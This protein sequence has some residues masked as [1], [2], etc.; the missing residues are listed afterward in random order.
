MNEFIKV[1]DIVSTCLNLKEFSVY[2]FGSRVKGTHRPD[3]DLD[4]LIDD[5]ITI[6]PSIVSKLEEAFEESGLPFKVD[7]VIRSRISDEFYNKIKGNIK[8]IEDF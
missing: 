3:S 8:K 6:D 5:K 1:K 4:I 2:L 7:I